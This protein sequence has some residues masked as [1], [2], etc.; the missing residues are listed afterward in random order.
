MH[1]IKLLLVD[2]EKSFIEPMKKWL[3]RKNYEVDAVMNGLD[4]VE[5]V[6]QAEGNYTVVFIDQTMLE[7]PDG[8]ETMKCIHQDYPDQYAIIFTGW[9][10]KESGVRAMKE[11]A[12][13][14]LSKP[15]DHDEIDILIESIAEK[16]AME[17][18]L[19]L[20]RAEKK[21]LQALLDVTQS[22]QNHMGHLDSV[23]QTIVDAAKT[24]TKADDCA[25]CLEDCRKGKHEVFSNQQTTSHQNWCSQFKDNSVCICQQLFTGIGLRKHIDIPD[26]SK[27]KRVNAA[28]KESGINSLLAMPVGK[29]GVIYAHGKNLDQFGEQDQRVLEMLASQ[30]AVAMQ[31]A[32]LLSEKERRVRELEQLRQVGTLMAEAVE[33]PDV[34][35]R[36]AEGVETLLQADSVAI[37]PY[38]GSRKRF[39]MESVTMIGIPQEEAEKAKRK[40]RPNGTA[41]TI[42]RKG[43]L[44]IENV[45]DPSHKFIGQSSQ[46]FFRRL[47][48]KCFAGVALKVGD[49][50]VGVLYLNFNDYKV[51]G[52]EAQATLKAFATEAALA[53]KKARLLQ[54]RQHALAHLERIAEFTLLGDVKKVL[55]GVA[56]SVK[57]TLKCDAVT[58]YQYD[59][60]RGIFIGSP[61]ASGLKDQK[62]AQEIEVVKPGTTMEVI[63]QQGEHYATDAASD[64]IMQGEFVPRENI[65]S[66]AG[67]VLRAS[68]HIVGVF[69]V[70]Y[71]T[72]YHFTEDDK[73]LIRAFAALAAIAI[74]NAELYEK[75]KWHHEHLHRLYTGTKI[76]SAAEGKDAILNVLLKETIDI[77]GFSGQKSIFANIQTYDASTNETI[78]TH[79]YPRQILLDNNLKIGQRRP[80]HEDTKRPIGIT[81]LAIKTKTTQIE[82]DV[83]KVPEIYVQYCSETRSEVAVPLIAEEHVIGV[84]NVENPEVGGLDE[85]DIR[86]IKLLAERASLVIQK[87][88]Q[89]KKLTTTQGL[90]VART[91][92]AWM[93]I[94]SSTWR[95][96]INKF[97]ATISDNV[98]L[99][100]KVLP[101]GFFRLL[102]RSR[103]NKIMTYLQRIKGRIKLIQETPIAAP[104]SAEEGV[105]S[106]Q[107]NALLKERISR[108]LEVHEKFEVKLHWFLELADETTVRAS[109][110]WL[111]RAVDI[112]VQNALEAMDDTPKKNLTIKTFEKPKLIEIHIVDT[113]KGIPPKVQSQILQE[114]IPKKK[115][116]RGAG[117]GL[118]LAQLIVQ[119][120]KGEINMLT[121]GP[122]GTEMAILFPLEKNH[123]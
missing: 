3:I 60:S 15:F 26:V 83:T 11:G 30:A 39:E 45:E 65:R 12:Y 9:G 121:T 85:Y 41:D 99:I 48:I 8:I 108:L 38:D 117:M 24:L 106:I 80:L 47:N 90:L 109:R 42:I 91:A 18:K 16:K 92:L 84:L 66:S 122:E 55:Q 34:L 82:P 29:V 25:I 37:W 46:K 81:G 40:P 20:T 63:L 77:T 104:L 7:G 118:L 17:R 64:A 87:T 74:Y 69:F 33:L 28:V 119:T 94:A 110:E 49:E 22:M 105:E 1:T 13:R 78:L 43:F 72:L 75:E 19:E 62:A 101:E 59:E 27:D 97:A 68:K 111:R 4:A 123:S 112:L 79:A 54:Q 67:I 86:A 120:Y 58:L 88:E 21:W 100:Q 44:F 93:G 6:R 115:E 98:H 23:L 102:G 116:D 95:H 32:L 113:G 52:T 5:K 50:S 61:V 107:L 56:K 51:F 73:R 70:N 31:N 103:F 36:L 71:R 35:G 14:Y 57:A 89:V 53:I 96:E 76:I 2:D 10:D 114:P